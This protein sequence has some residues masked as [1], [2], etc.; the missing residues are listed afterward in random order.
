MLSLKAKKILKKYI[1]N[2]ERF[3]MN[4][5]VTGYDYKDKEALERRM[6]V[7][8]LHMDNIVSMKEK[9]EILYAAAMLNNDGDMCGSTL[10]LELESRQAAEAYVENE[11]YVKGKVWEKVEIV[12]CKVPPL[13][14]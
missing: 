4:F 3:D 6:A 12:E 14:K 11:A 7:R 8:E 13:F 9:G 10:I 1:T 5:L 2:T